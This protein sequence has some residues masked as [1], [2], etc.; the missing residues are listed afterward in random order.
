MDSF[1]SRSQTKRFQ[2]HPTS[3][4]CDDVHF[5]LIIRK[6]SFLA[7]EGSIHL[8]RLSSKIKVT[9]DMEKVENTSKDD[10]EKEEAGPG[11]MG[12]QIKDKEGTA[13]KPEYE[14]WKK[15]YDELKKEHEELKVAFVQINQKIKQLETVDI[16]NDNS[17]LKH[18]RSEIIRV[19]EDYKQCMEAVKKETL[20]RNKAE[21]VAKTLTE[22]LKAY[23][24]LNKLKTV[25][26]D[27]S[28]VEDMV[29]DAQE[30]EEWIEQKKSNRKKKNKDIIKKMRR[31][32]SASNVEK[33]FQHMEN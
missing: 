2:H 8:R 15:S 12:W 25:N 31:N 13:T 7:Q 23:K 24:E 9:E 1:V 29:I 26:K 30:N 28:A 22:T 16:T 14:D 19:K 18:L 33:L 6:D 32:I 17:N 4:G 27:D 20:E 3:C 5:D 11:Y 10:Q 21:T